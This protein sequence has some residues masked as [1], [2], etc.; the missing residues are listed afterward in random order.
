MMEYLPDIERIGTM[1]VALF[2][3]VVGLIGLFRIK[4]V[5]VSLNSR[6]DE[7]LKLRGEVGEAKGAADERANPLVPRN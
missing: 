6:L 7:M 1:F 5:H 3:A 4:Q 2:G